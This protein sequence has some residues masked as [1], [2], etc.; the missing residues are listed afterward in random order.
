MQVRWRPETT[1]LELTGIPGV[2]S[3][4]LWLP[5]A[6]MTRSGAS[7]VY[8]MGF[9]W[10]VT[11]DTLLQEVEEKG[12]FGPGNCLRIDAQTLEC[13]GIRFPI[14]SPVRW[15]THLEYDA[16]NVE[17][18]IVLRNTGNRTIEQAMAPVCLSFVG[19][20]W[21][22]D[23]QVFVPV[24]GRL[25]P[26]SEL[27]R[28]AGRP[29]G[30]QMYLVRGATMD[31][32]FY[33][34]FWGVNAQRIDTGSMTSYNPET[35]TVVTVSSPCAIAV[36]SNLHNPCTDVMLAFGDLAPGTTARA[37]GEVRIRQHPPDQVADSL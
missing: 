16:W 19:A 10:R 26:L 18:E 5:E 4:L 15:E 29:N 24:G 2:G 17:Y 6:I 37:Q 7:A 14:D 35:D 20:S 30:F 21:W 9:P 25:R 23:S 33:R 8:P 1:Q 36:H 12:L 28:A 13:C 31:H 34:E 11:G 32:V 3:L 22:E 27:G